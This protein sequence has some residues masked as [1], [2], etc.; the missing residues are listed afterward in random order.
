MAYFETTLDDGNGIQISDDFS[1]LRL[2]DY[3]PRWPQVHLVAK[4]HD[5]S[6]HFAD[7]RVIPADARAGLQVFNGAGQCAFWSGFKYARVVELIEYTNSYDWI[8]RIIPVPAGRKYAVAFLVA[9]W[10]ELIENQRLHGGWQARW[11]TRRA[12]V[13]AGDSSHLKLGFIDGIWSDWSMMFE[14]PQPGR[15]DFRDLVAVVLDVT[16]Y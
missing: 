11:M 2:V 16:G 1:C 5:R 6:Y 3:E 13:I 10:Q 14:T 8:Y 7:D 4:S 9:P 15:P 12:G